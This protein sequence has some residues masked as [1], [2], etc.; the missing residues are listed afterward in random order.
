MGDL[1]YN[2]K[3]L[4]QYKEL[5]YEWYMKASIK[6]EKKAQYCLAKMYENG[7]VIAK[8]EK[9]IISLYRESADSGYDKAQ[10]EVGNDYYSR[11]NYKAALRFYKEAAKQGN[12]DAKYA[13]GIMYN[14]GDAGETDSETAFRYFKEAADGGNEDAI[15]MLGE[16][17]YKG[18]G[19]SKDDKKA[20][21][22]YKKYA[23][24]TKDLDA[25]FMVG[26][27][28]SKGEGVKQNNGEAKKWLVLATKQGHEGAKTKLKELNAL[29]TVS[30]K[31]ET[32]SKVKTTSVEKELDIMSAEDDE[33]NFD[34]AKSKF[35]EE[36]EVREEKKVQKSRGTNRRRNFRR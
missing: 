30:V 4:K 32:A 34:K 24:L 29:T 11:G 1:Y 26:Y 23:D 33:K 8:D 21:E 28:Y 9:K 15:Y 6:K 35:E 14:N 25:Q 31:K 16:M 17:Y 10:Y 20:F 22:Y 19:R 18:L 27:M 13:L 12:I 36:E 3:L 2:G 7:D 5:A